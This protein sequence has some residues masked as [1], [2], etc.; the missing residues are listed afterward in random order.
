VQYNNAAIMY[1]P[2]GAMT[3]ASM[4]GWSLTGGIIAGV[5][6]FGLRWWRERTGK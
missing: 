6:W 5:G 3:F 1:L 4:L 2:L